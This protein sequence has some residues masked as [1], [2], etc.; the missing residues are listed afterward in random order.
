MTEFVEQSRP[1]GPVHRAFLLLQ[2]VVAAGQPIGVRELARRADLSKSTT[3]RMLGILTDLGMV[4]RTSNG[5][6]RAGAGVE[7]LTRSTARSPAV[8]RERLRPLTVE[9]ARKFGENAAVGID[10]PEGFLYLASARS[11]AAVQV[12]DPSGETFPFHLVAP[13]IASMAEWSQGRLA[14]YLMAGLEAATRHSVVDANAVRVRLAA[15]RTDGFAWTN[16]ELDLDVNGLAVPIRDGAGAVIAV[17][18]LYGPSYRLSPTVSPGLAR[19]FADFVTART[20][21]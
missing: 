7:M 16:Q 21:S 10:T 1:I 8:L 3:A 18:S 9:L 17:A 4:E 13:G 6:A 11:Q 15:V 19:T 14:A 20:T 12:A 5:A 2:L